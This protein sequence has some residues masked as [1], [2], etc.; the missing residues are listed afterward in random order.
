MD[1][2]TNKMSKLDI[3]QT[4]YVVNPHTKRIVKIGTSSWK[5]AVIA[6]HLPIHTDYVKQRDADGNVSIHHIVLADGNQLLNPETGK[7]ITRLGKLHK[8]L[9]REK[10]M[11]LPEDCVATTIKRKDGAEYLA[12]KKI[13]IEPPTTPKDQPIVT[14]TPDAPRRQTKTFKDIIPNSNIS[15]NEYNEDNSGGVEDP[16]REIQIDDLFRLAEEG[17]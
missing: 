16:N 4:E 14:K 13:K 15:D 2:I 5:K 7:P 9:I 17:P 3:N 6:G 8:Q 11:P 1:S 12:I 10:K